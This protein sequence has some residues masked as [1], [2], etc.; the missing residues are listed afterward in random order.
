MIR[1]VL[2]G[3]CALLMLVAVCPAGETP[4]LRGLYATGGISVTQ[5]DGSGDGI[6][7]SASRYREVELSYSPTGPIP[8]LVE[9]DPYGYNLSTEL[10]TGYHLGIGY[11]FP[12]WL[13][14]N[15]RFDHFFAKSGDQAFSWQA[16]PGT[17]WFAYTGL[18]EY[19]ATYSIDQWTGTVE[20]F[21][22]WRG[23]FFTAGGGV[24]SYDLDETYTSLFLVNS[25][26]DSTA[27]TTTETSEDESFFTLGAGYEYVAGRTA[28]LVGTAG[29]VFK[30]VEGG[31][32]IH[33]GIRFYPF[34]LGR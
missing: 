5:L 3:I 25:L 26:E 24:V 33:A 29:Y 31:F 14:V 9:N 4:V 19:S 21:P 27:V 32:R 2:T 10:F 6:D 20:F 34:E 16:D 30:D 17:P 7:L 8:Q 28:S 13:G 18:V 15:G 11:R 23:L 12:R 22:G 1:I